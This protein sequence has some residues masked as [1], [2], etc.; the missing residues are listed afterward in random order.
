[1]ADK[2]TLRLKEE[3]E[4]RHGKGAVSDAQIKNFLST[5]NYNTSS[6]TK[7]FTDRLPYQ[8]SVADIQRYQAQ[9]PPT[10][11]EKGGLIN[12]VGAGLWTFFDTASFG[13]LSVASSMTEDAGGQSLRSMIDFSDTAAKYTGAIGG[14]AGFVGGAP[15]KV[16]G[17]LLQAVGG[18]VVRATGRKSI[19]QVTSQMLKKGAELGVKKDT[20]R[21]VTSHYANIARKAQSDVNFRKT[22]GEKATQLLTNYTDDAVQTGRITQAESVAIRKM[23][24][25]NYLNRPM[26]DFIGLMGTRMA[27]PRLAKVAGSFLNESIMFAMIDT[28]FEGV[29]MVEDQHFDW[30]RPVWGAFTGAVFSQLQWLNPVGKGA[31]WKLDFRAG[32][33]SAF[34]KKPE[35]RT[36]SDKQ[37]QGTGRFFGE[38]LR[39]FGREGNRNHMVNIEGKTI[40][41]KSDDILKQ[42]TFKFGGQQQGRDALIRFFEANRKMFGKEIMKASTIEALTNLPKNWFR[43]AAG[44]VAFNAHT[45]AEM[46]LHGTEP[47]FHDMLPHFLIGAFLQIGKNP[48][49]FDLDSHS[50]N[51]LRSN[52]KMLGVKVEQLNYVPSLARTPNRFNTGVNKSTHPET[53]KAYEE[54]GMGSNVIE[55]TEGKLR[56]GETSIERQGNA[57]FEKISQRMRLQFGHEKN[58]NNISTK[59]A[60]RL[61]EIFEAETGVKNLKDYDRHFDTLAVENTAVL[62]NTLPD[63][64]KEIMM[65]DKGQE[66]GF[67][68]VRSKTDDKMVIQG[69]ET[70]YPAE[71]IIKLAREGKLD[72]IKDLEGN[73]IKDGELAEAK[74]LETFDG[75]SDIFNTSKF[76]NTTTRLP[77]GEGTKEIRTLETV[78]DI[79]ESI[80]NAEATINSAFPSKMSYSN[81]FTF[82]SSAGDYIGILAQNLSIKNSRKIQ[83]IFSTEFS[84]RDRLISLMKEV[85]LLEGDLVNPKLLKNIQNIEFKKEDIENLPESERES[86]PAELRRGLKKILQLQSVTGGYERS[87]GVDVKTIS[88]ENAEKLIG[89]ISKQGLIDIHKLSEHVH[90]ETV[91]YII[92]DKIGSSNLQMY[93]MS[94]F[95]K[96]SEAGMANFNLDMKS[97]RQ[98][99]EIKLIDLA[100][101]PE[102]VKEQAN[103]YNDFARKIIQKSGGLIQS[104]GKQVVENEYDILGLSNLLPKNTK[105]GTLN[106]DKAQEHIYEFMEILPTN[107]QIQNDV[108]QYSLEGNSGEILNWLLRSGV[109]KYDSNSSKKYELNPKKFTEELKVQLQNKIKKDGFDD[110]YIKNTIATEEQAA[111]AAHGDERFMIA[112]DAK[113]DMNTFLEKY[114]IEGVD[115]SVRSKESKREVFDSLFLSEINDPSLRIPAPQIVENVLKRIEVKNTTTNEFVKF[116]DISPGQKSEV[117]KE[118]IGDLVK[119]IA[120]QYNTRKVNVFKFENGQLKEKSEFQQET[121]LNSLYREL[122]LAHVN[123]EKESVGYEFYGNKIRRVFR[124]IFENSSDLPSEFRAP[125]AKEMSELKRQLKSRESSFGLTN[126]GGMI[127]IQASKDTSPIAVPLQNLPNMHPKYIEFANWALKQK[128]IDRKVK[129][130]IFDITEKIKDPTKDVD[131]VAIGKPTNNDYRYMLSQLV[132]NDMLRGSKKTSE[133]ENFLNGFDVSKTMGR[134]KLH[135]SKNFV[136]HDRQLLSSMMELY[137]KELKDKDTFEAIGKIMK[138]DGFNIAIWNDKDYAN[139]KTEV[140]DILKKNGFSQQ[141][142]DNFLNNVIGE[143]HEGV[144]SFDSIAL[145][146]RRIMRYSHGMM[147]NN[148]NSTNP[149]KP[150]IS[151]GGRSGQLLLGKTL[152]VYDKSLDSFFETNPNV[153]ILL[154]STGAK[155]FNKGIQRDGLD[156]SVINKSFNQLNSK[157]PIGSQKIRKIPIDAIGFKPEV[158]KPIKDAVE[159]T[160]DY[161]YMKQSES[162]DMYNENYRTDIIAAVN[163]MKTITEDPIRIRRFVLDM[164]GSDAFSANPE[165]GGSQHL[166]N[167]YMFSSM[168]RDANPMSYSENIVKNK[169]YN[170]FV[171]SILNGKRSTAK[172]ENGTEVRYGGQAPIIQATGEQYRLKPTYVNQDGVMEMR[173]EM[174]IGA[175]EKS[176]SVSDIVK[177]GRKMI[178]V[179]GAKTIDPREFFGKYKEKQG[180]QQIEKDYWDDMLDAGLDLGTL[181]K[182]LE[183][184]KTGVNPYS[185][186]L[187]I[188]VVVNR[189]PHTRPNDNAILGLKGFLDKAFGRSALVN[190][191]DIVNIFEGDYDADKVDYF[192][193]A[194]KAVHEHAKRA[195]DLFVQGIDP[196]SIKIDKPFSWGDNPAKVVENIQ[197]MAA[198]ADLAK[199]TIGVV[200]KIPRK[201]SYLNSIAMDGK[202]DTAL[203]ARFGADKKPKILFTTPDIG[204]AKGD[205]FRITI[206]FDNLDYFSRAALETQYMLD[207]GGGVNP[208]LMRDVTQWNDRFL[209]PPKSESISPARIKQKG[210]GFIQ[211]N[212]RRKKPSKRIRIFRKFDKNGEELVL[213][214]LDKAMIKTMMSE[215][216]KFLNA[217]GKKSFNQATGEQRSVSYDDIYEASDSFFNF[218]RDLS[219]SLYYKLR[220]KKD[221]FGNSFFNDAQFKSMFGAERNTYTKYE[222]NK[223]VEKVYYK[224]SK[225]M[226]GDYEQQI[227]QNSLSISNGEGGGVIERS[228]HNMWKEDVFGNRTNKGL[229]SNA[230]FETG[231]QVEYMNRW[232]DQLRTGDISEYSGSVDAMQANI[233]KTVTDYNKAAYY[234]GN[235]KQK[236]VTTQYRTDLQYKSKKAI[237]DK[238]NKVIREVE[239]KIVDELIPAEYRETYKSKDLKPFKFVPILGKE[240]SEAQIQFNTIDSLLRLQKDGGYKL[241][242]DGFELLKYLKDIRRE[243]YSNQEN[244]GDIYK[245]KEKTVLNRQKLD[246]L[247]NMPDQTTF[248]EIEDAVFH[249]GLQKYGTPFILEFMATTR[250]NRTIGIQNGRLVAKPFSSSGRF[251]R[252]YQFLTSVVNAPKGNDTNVM[253]NYESTQLV[254]ARQLIRMLQVTE[255][256]F[257][258]FQDRRFDQR[259]FAD[260]NFMENI[261]TKKEPI[262]LS[263]EHIRLPSFGRE[264][265]NVIGDYSSIRWARDTN[266]I[267]SGFDNMNDSLL[268]Y[269]RE[270]MEIAGKGP[271]FEKYVETMHGLKQ[272]MIKNKTIDPIL[273][274]ATK[275]QIESDVQK[276]ANKVLT[277]GID[278]KG[279]EAAYQRLLQNPMH[280]LNGGD[281]ETGFFRGIS[282]ETKTAYSIKRLK[283]VVKIHE[284]LSKGEVEQRFRTERGEKDLKNFIEKCN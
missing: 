280:I 2:L 94:T 88:I 156:T 219:K 60:Q 192:Y 3:L 43:M 250:D 224:P 132:F 213:N 66:L 124:N 18:G 100:F 166:S 112:R 223:P 227:K 65:A 8:T 205:K 135:D 177:S 102:N 109:M 139:V 136:K 103:E 209:F 207:M 113:F 266:R 176:V 186:D 107:S 144:S 204:G 276:I 98:G 183:V 47:G 145:V 21:E 42:A 106:I 195:S 189:K 24:G 33:R 191:L 180:K 70:I 249:Q 143:A 17:K 157:V 38:S 164:F 247:A 232:Y 282:L 243:F 104:S 217:A 202:N 116:K 259:N 228:L 19:N 37:L 255:A 129:D 211:D 229:E 56:E 4:R 48:A 162:K 159:S 214:D 241:S 125:I 173:G 93:E 155:A 168:H 246:F 29:T 263:L 148:P 131:G 40:N 182:I 46:A 120:S 11:D 160:S 51:Q 179:D 78:K 12:A 252:G 181:Y 242:P 194:R 13:A 199:K 281:A 22:F 108:A 58:P 236:I 170:H 45:L 72:F 146:P 151:S 163:G 220:Y 218:N 111:R 83:N 257:R 253:A 27:N 6:P 133:L 14:L 25:D 284:D 147:G 32:V 101:V 261:G 262:Y 258:R 87:E 54:L 260:A 153:D 96:I 279:N 158:D 215:Y 31:K 271:E 127:I 234:I 39:R 256:N 175:H 20:A 89:F 55:A 61:V 36:W 59:E 79:Y 275:A 26:Q 10:Q 141:K 137:K 49:S 208:E 278:P 270:I 269:Y 15:I 212:I 121:R 198:S 80:V 283:E 201:L 171:N 77:V 277:G 118:I 92:R 210:A 128:N 221:S 74:L 105:E 97:G 244:L 52:L 203:K 99:F 225:N 81:A 69:P 50:M 110:N 67:I 71:S 239:S 240:A 119:L 248:R 206:D 233:M 53:L 75:Y 231:T 76:L 188:G 193:G 63:V 9:Q 237:I 44:G 117:K 64:V 95:F 251:R 216:G 190:S 35:Y 235:L 169:I 68:E 23:F 185:K 196:T 5:Q 85:G 184:G 34:S 28:I 149:V 152:L 86:R 226:F 57:K 123:I 91:N 172:L 82:S 41:L 140:A 230:A 16:G 134:I 167:L 73:V 238:L 130:Q 114:N 273:Y 174:M 7:R 268:S 178:F 126:T 115:Y 30:T 90:Q 187:Q 165:S 265:E 138:Q 154:T 254:A 200:Q 84:G 122:E 197:D 62:E 142:I 1:M 267:K 150:A 161:N 222:N 264:L 272:D 245:Y 274:L